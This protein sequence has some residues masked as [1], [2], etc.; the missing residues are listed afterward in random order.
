MMRYSFHPEAEAEFLQ[1]I[2]YYEECKVGLGEDFAYEIYA[3]LERV[4]LQPQKCGL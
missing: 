1:A 4:I 2:D 3:A